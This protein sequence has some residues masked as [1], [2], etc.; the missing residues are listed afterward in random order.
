MS[1]NVESILQNIDLIYKRKQVLEL[2]GEPE[3][4]LDPY[5]ENE[6]SKTPSLIIKSCKNNI[7][8]P[9]LGKL[10]HLKKLEIKCDL[11]ELPEEIGNLTN[12]TELDLSKNKLTSLP[13]EIGNLTNLTKLNLSTNRQ[14]RNLPKEIGNLTNLTEL[15]LDKTDIYSLLHIENLTNLTHLH[16]GFNPRVDLEKIKNL[17]NLKVLEI[18]AGTKNATL[19]SNIQ[20]LPNINI[21]EVG[22]FT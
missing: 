11:K 20:N 12:L 7:L 18:S 3:E 2:L 14:L 9:G 1:I 19:P 8:Y 21:Y 22:G 17:T 5:T 6:K 4:E 10:T 13:K 16:L 15:H